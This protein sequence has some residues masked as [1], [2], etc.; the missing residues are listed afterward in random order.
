MNGLA[1]KHYGFFDFNLDFTL[2]IKVSEVPIFT[3]P[4]CDLD[5]ASYE[6]VNYG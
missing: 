1:P 2:Q 6:I 5:F 3:E 4:V